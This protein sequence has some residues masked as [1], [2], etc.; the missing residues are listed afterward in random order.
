MEEE[1]GVTGNNPL[2]PEQHHQTPG[3][4]PET[5]GCQEDQEDA[6]A[7]QVRDLRTN[8]NLINLP[9]RHLPHHLR[10]QVPHEAT[11]THRL[12]HLGSNL[13]VHLG[14]KEGE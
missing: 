14:D 11:Q 12:R 10:L 2:D 5:K 7:P 6:P 1:V 3:P 4:L 13:R 9:L 8:Q